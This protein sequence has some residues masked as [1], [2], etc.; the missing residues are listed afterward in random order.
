[1]AKKFLALAL[2]L[3]L[4]VSLAACTPPATDPTQPQQGTNPKDPTQQETLPTVQHNEWAVENKIND[5]SQT[6]AELYELAKKEASVVLYSISSRCTKVADSFNAQ[7]PG[8][9]CEA[10]DLGS[11]EIVEKITREHEAG[12]VNCDVVH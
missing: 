5:G 9:V 2:V 1:M 4:V 8:V 11:G 3:M 7:Y 6:A 12:I 10:Y